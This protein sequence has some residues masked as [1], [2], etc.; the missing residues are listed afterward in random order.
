MAKAIT[1]G[2]NVSFGK[3]LKAL[4]VADNRAQNGLK[5]LGKTSLIVAYVPPIIA[6]LKQL[7]LDHSQGLF[8]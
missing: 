2:T 8:Y 4:K 7:C 1:E 6:Q 3:H 5:L